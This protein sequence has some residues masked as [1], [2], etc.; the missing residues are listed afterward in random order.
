MSQS[1]EE[2][3]SAV[4]RLAAGR[5]KARSLRPLRALAPF[6]GPYRL[7]IWIAGLALLCSSTASLLIPPAVRG[8]IDHGFS[9]AMAAQIDRFFLPLIGIAGALALFTAIRFYFV[10]WLG[11]RVIADIRGPY[12]TTSSD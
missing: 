1:G 11:E 10:A 3:A 7:Q 4:A 12:L 8:M 2:Y 5:A 9:R 6:L